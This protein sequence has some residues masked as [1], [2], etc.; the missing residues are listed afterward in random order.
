MEFQ[1]YAR[2]FVA[3]ATDGVHVVWARRCQSDG[4]SHD[5]QSTATTGI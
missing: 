3:L 5:A 1:R 2:L 4:R